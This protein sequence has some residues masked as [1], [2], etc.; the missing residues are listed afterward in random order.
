MYLNMI[1]FKRR[2]NHCHRENKTVQQFL[3][4]TVHCARIV[5]VKQSKMKGVQ[6]E[7]LNLSLLGLETIK[8]NYTQPRT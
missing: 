1:M 8:L 7:H 6:S 5:K 4:N 2:F 3:L